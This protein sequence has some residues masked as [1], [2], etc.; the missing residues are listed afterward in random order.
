M[1]TDELEEM[2][3][4]P[5]FGGVD[6]ARVDAMLKASFLQRFPAH[7]E[8]VREG[9]PADFLHLIVEGQVETFAA[10]RGRETTIAVQGAGHAFI[11]AA[12]ILDKVYLKSARTLTA[13]R[14]LMLPADAVRSTFAADPVF[15]RVLSIEMALSYRAVI[16]ELKNQKLRSSIERLANWL[17]AFG[18]ASGGVRRF[19]L[20][21]DKKVLASHLGM[22]PE[23]LSRCFANLSEF[24]VQVSGPEIMIV[25]H[26]TL[27]K[28]ARPEP[29]IDDPRT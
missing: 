11:I 6:E 23:V 19:M 12:V 8:L 5:L 15:C 9:D 16:K 24:G 14:I 25:D 28:L 20:P 13:S 4:L 29:T 10:Y 3:R 21:F 27:L 17:V 2:R 26:E 1:R 22:V 7:V 18:A